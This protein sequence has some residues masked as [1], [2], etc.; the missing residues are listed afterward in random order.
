MLKIPFRRTLHEQ[1]LTLVELARW[2]PVAAL[3][4]I[5][6]GS[7]SALLLV[8]LNYATDL[9]ERHVWLILFLAPAGWFVAQMY[10]RLGSSV[11]AGN[12][13]VLE[14]AHDPTATISLWMTPLILIGTFI[15]HVFGGSAGREGT[16]IQT[17]A[18][19]A[20]QLA[21]P[22][23]M[24]SHDRRILLMMGISAGFASVFGTPLAGA[25]F[26]LEVL[27][28]G[29]IS[30]E[31]IAPCF[32]AAFTGDLITAAWGVQHTIYRV[33]IVP[34]M[35]VRGVVYSM[36]AGV[37]FGL[38]GMV[39]AKMTHAV[40]HLARK[41][42]ASSTLR[43]VAGG[44]LISV[45]V[46]GIGTS[47]MLRYVG[48]GI[49]TIVASF[50]TKVDPYDF[51][52]KSVLTAITLGTGFKGGEVTPLF[53]IGATLGNALSNWIPLPAS[54]LAGMGFV[55]VFSGAANTP[56]ASTFMAVE[57]FGAEAGSYAGIAC[58]LAYLFS[59]HVGIYSAQRLGKSK[60][61][62]HI[63]EEGLSLAVIAKSRAELE[64]D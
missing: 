46:F 41:Y 50:R 47:H 60:H 33:S 34:S 11:E 3:V 56:I 32:M 55:A 58:V 8:S 4:G 57:L 31:A 23:R 61:R 25:V 29:T 18:S 62:K 36:I 19:L 21:R 64:Q 37:L 42:I 16:A 1:R 9:R 45:A 52:A 38:V 51:A 20:D 10:Q 44:L 26:G 39:F 17:G 28:I 2:I 35:N 13:L 48:L 24:A 59:G 7:A 5:L 30:Y 53:Y 43:P 49:P 12:N 63:A 22:L 40:S 14:Q 27:A 54:L 6:A 15:T